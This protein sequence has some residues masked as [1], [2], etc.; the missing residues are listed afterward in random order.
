MKMFESKLQVV[1]FAIFA[2]LSV[3]SLI[4]SY[5]NQGLIMFAVMSAVMCF[6]VKKCW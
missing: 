6:A 1:F 4:G 3:A 5:Y 2:M